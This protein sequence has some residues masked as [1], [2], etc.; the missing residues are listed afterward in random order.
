MSAY[1]DKAGET[2]RWVVKAS[3]ESLCPIRIS[4]FLTNVENALENFPSFPG[5]R[6]SST[7]TSN[8]NVKILYNILHR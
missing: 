5:L 4:I 2:S 3:D 8:I 1:A 7:I 6:I